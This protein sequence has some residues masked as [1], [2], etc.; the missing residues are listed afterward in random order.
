MPSGKSDGVAA[1]IQGAG[2]LKNRYHTGGNKKLT[3]E[4]ADRSVV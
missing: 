4:D 3:F 2:L 1:T